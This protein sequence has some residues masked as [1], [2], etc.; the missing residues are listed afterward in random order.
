MADDKTKRAPQDK[1]RIAMGEDYEIAYWS[2]KFGVGKDTLAEAV[3]AVGNSAQKVA[4]F[5][6]KRL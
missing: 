2:K 1:S 5:L 4:D 6:N 3:S